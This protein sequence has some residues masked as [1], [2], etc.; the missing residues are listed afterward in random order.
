LL[1]ACISS[2]RHSVYLTTYAY[3]SRK[4]TEKGSKLNYFVHSRFRER[5][6]VSENRNSSNQRALTG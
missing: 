2:F 1:A 3:E 4:T 5:E 6:R